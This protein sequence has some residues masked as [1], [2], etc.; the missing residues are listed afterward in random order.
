MKYVI[1]S[2]SHGSDYN[3][4]E[5]MRMHA[6]TADGI[7]FAGDGCLEFDNLALLY[8]EKHTERV[9]GNYEE[10]MLR[11]Q[12]D[13]QSVFMIGKYRIFLTHGHRYNV[14]YGYSAIYMKARELD[15]DAV[16]FGHTHEQMLEYISGEDMGRERPLYLFNPGSISRPRESR[17]PTYGILDIAKDQIHFTRASLDVFGSGIKGGY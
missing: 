14:K 5:A 3:M 17:L 12:Y 8:P 16:I 1:F 15:V 13:A 11:S 4:K 2:D 6:A 9:A 10:L 7:L